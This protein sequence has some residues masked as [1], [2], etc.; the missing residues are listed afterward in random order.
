MADMLADV[1]V[2][3]LIMSSRSGRGRR[4]TYWRVTGVAI[5]ASSDV[6]TVWDIDPGESIKMKTSLAF[7]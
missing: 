3:V 5:G 1:E 4:D 7:E 6:H 2:G